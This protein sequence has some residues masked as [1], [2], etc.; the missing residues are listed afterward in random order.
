MLQQP[1]FVNVYVM[2]VANLPIESRAQQQGPKG[3]LN[4]AASEQ[5]FW[6]TSLGF[7]VVTF[8]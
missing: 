2:L 8:C 4:S 5:V 3:S 7:S 1:G 6:V